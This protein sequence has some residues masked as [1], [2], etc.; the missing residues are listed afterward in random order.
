MLFT[1]VLLFGAAAARPRT[2]TPRRVPR[3]KVAN[4]EKLITPNSP[5]CIP[6]SRGSCIG[7]ARGV[8]L[9]G[10]GVVFTAEVN[11]A[12]GPVRTPFHPTITK[13]EIARHRDKKLSACPML[14]NAWTRSLARRPGHARTLP[15]SR[16]SSCSP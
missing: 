4:A 10:Y 15:P 5:P 14:R 16:Q 9:E 11:L 6:K 2:P 3:A 7:P 12:T 1:A 8:Y 13:E